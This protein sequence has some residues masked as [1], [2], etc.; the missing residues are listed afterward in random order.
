MPAD[1]RE[2]LHDAAARD[3]DGPDVDAILARAGRLRA[4]RR[5]A[6]GVA[7]LVPLA[8]LAFAVLPG[9]VDVGLVDRPTGSVLEVLTAEEQVAAAFLEDGTPVFVSNLGADGVAVLDARVPYQPIGPGV[10]V[11]A[12]WCP[13][14]GLFAEVP[15]G[16]EFTPDGQYLAGPAPSGLLPYRVEQL[17]SRRVR[18]GERGSAPARAS[19]A[20]ARAESARQGHD[21]G[22]HEAPIAQQARWH[23]AEHAARAPSP[24]EALESTDHG[25]VVVWGTLEYVGI[26]SPRLCEHTDVDQAKP[27]EV[28][29]DSDDAITTSLPPRQTEQPDLV[30]GYR[31]VLLLDVQ[32]GEVAHVTVAGVV[33]EHWGLFRG[34]RTVR[35]TLMPSDT[36]PDFVSVLGNPQE[37]SDPDLY[38]QVDY[39]EPAGLWLTDEAAVTGRSM[40]AGTDDPRPVPVERLLAA[41]ENGEPVRLDVT[42]RNRDGVIIRIEE[43]PSSADVSPGVTEEPPPGQD[44]G[45]P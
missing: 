8:V 41:A 22:G 10:D 31:G 21:C 26:Q 44:P 2:V 7:V 43:V 20:A 24:R 14:A 23:Y 36:S 29:C 5:V 12:L 37:G 1:M 34:E 9:R 11:L 28:Q 30:W 4:R 39:S 33:G 42:V 17:D 40:L 25:R 16:S 13:S 38:V 3:E 15:G 32:G 27:T 18:V 45:Q 6:A 19:D 35:G